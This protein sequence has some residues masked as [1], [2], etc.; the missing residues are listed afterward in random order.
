MTIMNVEDIPFDENIKLKKSKLF[1]WGVVYPWRNDDGTFNWKHFLV[2]GSWLNFI[3]M[4]LF[5]AILILLAVEY[6][7]NLQTCTE[8]INQYNAITNLG[9]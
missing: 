6:N 2:G 5:I 3:G 9:S 8:V 7:Q 1:G 4:V